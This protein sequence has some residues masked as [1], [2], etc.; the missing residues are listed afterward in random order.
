M[1]LCHAQVSG[2]CD[3]DFRLASLGIQAFPSR[4]MK[5]VQM[6]W[7]AAAAAL[8]PATTSKSAAT[9][10]A[11]RLPASNRAKKQTILKQHGATR[12][13]HCILGTEHLPRGGGFFSCLAWLGLWKFW[14]STQSACNSIVYNFNGRPI[15]T[16]L[17]HNF[18][19]LLNY[20]LRLTSN[21]TVKGSYK[22]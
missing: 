10:R 4:H 9:A 20:S 21:N 1:Q 5:M 14:W 12:S 18:A 16:V 11:T 3:S 7:A 22:F 15:A 13:E 6:F 8:E 19:S 2:S 17:H